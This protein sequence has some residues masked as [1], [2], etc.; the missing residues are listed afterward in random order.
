MILK[1]KNRR[2][3]EKKDGVSAFQGVSRETPG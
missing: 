1:P 3:S 2:P